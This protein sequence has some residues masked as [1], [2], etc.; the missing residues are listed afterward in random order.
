MNDLKSR[1]QSPISVSRLD[2]CYDFQSCLSQEPCMS[3]HATTAR[4]GR[5]KAARK[6]IGR[7]KQGEWQVLLS[8][9]LRQQAAEIADDIA[10]RLIDT[11]LLLQNFEDLA[12]KNE[13]E[14]AITLWQ[15]AGVVQGFPGLAMMCY[16]LERCEPGV[17]WGRVGTQFLKIASKNQINEQSLSFGS[18]ADGAAGVGLVASFCPA[19]STWRKQLGESLIGSSCQYAHGLIEEMKVPNRLN[20]RHFDALY[21]ISGVGRYLLKMLP[22]KQAELTLH[23]IL[24]IFIELSREKDEMLGFYTPYAGMDPVQ[25]KTEECGLINTGLAHGVPGPLMV[26]SLAVLNGVEINGLHEATGRLADWLLKISF[27]DSYGINWPRCVPI[28]DRGLEIPPLMP[29]RVAWCYGTPGIARTLWVAGEALNET[30]YK[31]IAI[32]SMEAALKKPQEEQRIDAPTICH[33]ISGVL[34]IAL[35]FAMD[36]KEAFFSEAVNSMTEKLISYYDPKHY[37]G[38]QDVI[39]SVKVDN[40]G[41]LMGASG[42]VLALLAAAYPVEPVWD[43]VLLVS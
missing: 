3:T 33:G 20:L 28:N 27:K 41:F 43:E 29:S 2:K 40:A 37:W 22:D 6:G 11:D 10:N 13:L 32:Q 39:R 38:F 21:G 12:S 26:M 30:R 14:S 25:R 9:K 31:E 7:K 36:T 8:D 4:R 23:R 5:S 16:Q 15:P 42:V 18:I 35:R 1:N 17:G 19:R 34:D 24:E